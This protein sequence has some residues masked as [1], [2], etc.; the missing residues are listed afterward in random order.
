MGSMAKGAGEYASASGQAEIA[1]YNAAVAPQVAE[2]NAVLAEREAA[3]A[4]TAAGIEAG[5]LR[6]EGV[7]TMGAVAATAGRSGS[8]LVGSPLLVMLDAGIQSE[9]SALLR[10]YQ[11][12]VT[13]TAKEAEAA[14]T[15]WQGQVTASQQNYLAKQYRR[16]AIATILGGASE[17]SGTLS[18]MKWGTRTRYSSDYATARDGE[19]R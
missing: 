13:A 17:A 16:K 7:R 19:L 18:G 9:R 1:S 5:A 15:R 10:T 8:A 14:G 6:R 4:R 2:Y 12:E 11:G 3:S